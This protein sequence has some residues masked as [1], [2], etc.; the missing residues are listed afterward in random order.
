MYNKIML[1]AIYPGTIIDYD[2]VEQTLTYEELIVL[3]G[4]EGEDCVNGY[5][6]TEQQ[7]IFYIHLHP[8]RDNDYPNITDQV[9]LGDEI[10]WGPDFDGKKKWTM[11]TDYD[12]LYADQESE[13]KL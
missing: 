1:Y 4:V 3:Y 6:L 9:D 5:S 10:K 8:R 12:K 2:D 11:E 13:E 7:K